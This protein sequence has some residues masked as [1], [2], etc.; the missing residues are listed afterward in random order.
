MV[1]VLY[2]NYLIGKG[3]TSAA[4]EQLRVA[5]GLSTDDANLQYNLGLAYFKLKKYDMAL[6]HAQ[7]AYA[8]GFPLPGLREMLMSVGKW[9]DPASTPRTGKGSAQAK[10]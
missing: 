2:G 6:A 1:R 10:N 7:K 9:Q 5:D 4:L 3:D 8:A